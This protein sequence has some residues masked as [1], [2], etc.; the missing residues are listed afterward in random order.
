LAAISARVVRSQA[1]AIAAL[2]VVSGAA[3]AH[4]KGFHT[5]IAFSVSK[6][7]VDALLVMD[8]DGGDKCKLLRQGVDMNRDGVLEPE[9]SEVLKKKLVAMATRA[10]K[11]GISSAPVPLQVKDVKMSLREDRGANSDTGLSV[12][13]MLEGTHPHEVTPGMSLEVE[14]TSPDFS[15]VV[16]EISALS[17]RD[18]GAEAVERYELPA[19]EKHATRLGVLAAR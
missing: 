14:D 9:E 5:R 12:A 8:V 17:A 15:P 13:L 10:L 11:V 1:L 16:V 7:A 19:A 3:A 2:L 6:F 18:G 4:P